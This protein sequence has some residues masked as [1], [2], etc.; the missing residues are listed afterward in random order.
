[1]KAIVHTQ[2]GPPEELKLQEV[3]KPVPGDKEVL[4][5]IHASTVTTTDCNV[6]NFTFVPKSFIFIA[7]MMF[8]SKKPKTKI[9]GFDFAGEVEA[10][11]KDVTLFK[12]GDMV[13]GTRDTAFGGHAEYV[14]LPERGVLVKKPASLSWEEAAALPLAG[15][16]ALTYIRDWGKIAAGQK[17]LIVGASGGIGTY[18]V[19]LAK[20]YG[21]EVTGVCSTA[22]LDLVKSLGA[23]HTVDYTKDDYLNSNRTYDVVFDTVGK[24]SFKQSKVLL[25]KKGLYLGAAF[26]MGEMLLSIWKPIAGGKQ[27]KGGSSVTTIKGLEFLAE[28]AVTGKIKSVIDRTYK[29]EQMAEAFRYV[30]TGHKK[31]NVAIAVG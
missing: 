28:L 6:R 14:C 15:S 5:K 10:A 27:V 16:T 29:L 21:A 25:K 12:K 17:I 3:E 31:G 26:E 11:G 30:E 18:A 19:Q 8:G 2:Y 24:C 20:Y 9:L 4:V 22:N 1:M 7:K 23:D 13:F